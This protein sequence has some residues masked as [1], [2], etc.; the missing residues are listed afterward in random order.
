M[1]G[2]DKRSRSLFSY[3]DL[4]DRVRAD[5]PLRTDGSGDPPASG[6]NGERDLPLRGAFQRHPPE[7]D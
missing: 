3:V 4:E 5:H 7:H 2:A 6:R 1:R